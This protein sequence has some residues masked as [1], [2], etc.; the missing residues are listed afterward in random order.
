MKFYD[1]VPGEGLANMKKITEYVK[2]GDTYEETGNVTYAKVE[3][4]DE[5]TQQ[6]TRLNSAALNKITSDIITAINNSPVTIA[7][8]S[9]GNPEPDEFITIASNVNEGLFDDGTNTMQGVTG[10]SQR[11]TTIVFEA[12]EVE[13][14]H[15]YIWLKL[16][17]KAEKS[18][19][20]NGDQYFNFKIYEIYNG[21]ETLIKDIDSGHFSFDNTPYVEG[22]LIRSHIEAGTKKKYK[23]SIAPINWGGTY[24]ETTFSTGRLTWQ[25]K[26][27]QISYEKKNIIELE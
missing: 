27:F 14:S 16:N 15:D 13:Y 4:N 7:R 18:T 8:D 6:G 1:R 2:D 23:I 21:I 25:L 12:P 26:T 9:E 19:T 10:G 5:A 17:I 20:Y 3:Y 24:P 11:K 22:L